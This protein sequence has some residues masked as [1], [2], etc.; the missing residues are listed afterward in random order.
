MNIEYFVSQI[1]NIEDTLHFQ[2]QLDNEKIEDLRVKKIELKS[3]IEEE[4]NNFREDIYKNPLIYINILE[5]SNLESNIDPF[6]KI[7]CGSQIFRTQII[8][9]SRNPVWNESYKM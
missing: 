8:K 1:I 7:L 2:I 5:A 3:R 4:T 6:V 9:N